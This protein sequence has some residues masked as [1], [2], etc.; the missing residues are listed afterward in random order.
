MRGCVMRHTAWCISLNKSSCSRTASPTATN[1]TARDRSR[2]GALASGVV[3]AV[4]PL[5]IACSG[6]WVAH[7]SRGGRSRTPS[8]D[9]DGCQGAS[10]GARATGSAA[11]GC[12]K[13]RS[14]TTTRL[15]QQ[16]AVAAVPPHLRAAGVSRRRFPRVSG[17]ERAIRARGVRGSAGRRRVVLVQDYHFALAPLMIRQRAAVGRDRDVLAHP[18][19]ALADVCRRVPGSASCSRAC[20]AARVIGFQTSADCFNFVETVDRLLGARDRLRRRRHHL[21][22]PARSS[23]RDYPTS[24]EWPGQWARAAPVSACRAAVRRDLRLDQRVLLGVGLDR[25]GFHQGHRGEVPGDRADARDARAICAA[26]SC[27][28]SWPSPAGGGWPP[29]A[30]RGSACCETADRI[31]RRFAVGRVPAD[32][33]PRS[34]SLARRAS[35]DTSAPPMSAW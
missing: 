12:P 23:V 3:N 18:V 1:A 35:P 30:R 28:C 15:C 31:N 21:P 5:L 34:A 10:R 25:T 8:I 26:D 22:R 20:W 7:G 32:P 13:K 27:S 2:C 6:V 4:E 19:A 9:R 29:I 11:S 16:R 14:A 17:G 33:G 24:I